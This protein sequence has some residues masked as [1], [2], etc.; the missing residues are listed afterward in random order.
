MAPGKILKLIAAVL[1]CNLAGFA[2]SVFT[3]PSI[4]TWYASLNKPAFTPPN[5]VFAPAWTTLFVLMGIGLY[6]VWDR[7]NFS[8]KGRTALYVFGFQLFLNV[9]WSV[10]FFGLQSPFYAFVEII[11]L[12]IAILFTIMK[13]REID[14]KA[15]YVLVPY[16]AWVTFAALLN[17][18]VWLLNP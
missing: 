9:M 3:T 2:G 16:I 8:G 11:A 15:G 17:L 1:I 12:W 4:P 14:G 5:W 7:T 6:L 13:F 10:L 18:S